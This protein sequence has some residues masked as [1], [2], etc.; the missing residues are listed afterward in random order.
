[1]LRISSCSYEGSL[2]GWNIPLNESEED[3]L[4]E[5]KFDYGFHASHGSLKSIACS[6]SGKYMATGGMNERISVYSLTDNQEMGELA[7]HS[8]AITYLQFFDDS[9][10]VSAS[11]DNTMHI[12]RCYDWEN[13]H[14]LG[15]HK[16][17]VNAFAIHQS[18]KIALSVSRDKTL[19]IWNLVQGRCS[20]S[21]KLSSSGEFV[22]WHPRGESYLVG[23]STSIQVYSTSTNET[24]IDNTTRSRINHV[25]F[26]Q[27]SDDTFH[28]LYI[29]DDQTLNILNMEGKIVRSLILNTLGVGR[30]KSFVANFDVVDGNTYISFITSNGMLL[31]IDASSMINQFQSGERLSDEGSELAKST[32]QMIRPSQSATAN[33]PI[34]ASLVEKAAKDEIIFASFLVAYHQLPSEP[35]LVSV[36]GFLQRSSSSTSSA[37]AIDEQVESSVAT[38]KSSLEEKKSK[39]KDKKRKFEQSEEDLLPEIDVSSKKSKKTVGF[40]S[41][42][43]GIPE[44]VE[45]TSNSHKSAGKKQKK[46]KK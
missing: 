34:S 15:G 3:I 4:R 39:K 14:I 5:V 2:F 11:E 10:L 27:T 26:V 46:I 16:D 41:V 8:G 29:C 6:K 44:A 22:M 36:S 13:I 12:W 19:K 35:R 40:S 18:G 31:V 45:D 21:K 20:L 24:I 33:R 9:F 42:G 37:A 17:T 32:L 25:S 7:G 38:E 43:N 1:M 28:I 23:T 30:L